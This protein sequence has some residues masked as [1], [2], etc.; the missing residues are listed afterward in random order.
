[1]FNVIN[2]LTPQY[3]QELFSFR[4]HSY[5]LRDYENKRTLPKL[6]T[7]YLEHGLC[8]NGPSL[9]NTLAGD[10]RSCESLGMFKK[11]VYRFFSTL[12]SLTAIM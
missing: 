1:M 6:R 7:D 12:Y 2:N 9:C 8:Y 5:N 10:L 3:L 11:G 4:N